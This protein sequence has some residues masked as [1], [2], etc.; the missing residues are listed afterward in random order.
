MHYWG[1]YSQFYI[2]LEFIR[3][4]LKAIASHYLAVSSKGKSENPKL[5]FVEIVNIVFTFVINKTSVE[6]A[7]KGIRYLEGLTYTHRAFKTLIGQDS[8]PEQEPAGRFLAT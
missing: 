8:T 7:L 4:E 3:K 1:L 6:N 2:K 5:I